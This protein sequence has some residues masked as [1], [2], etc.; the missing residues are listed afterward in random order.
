MHSVKYYVISSG[1]KVPIGWIWSGVAYTKSLITLNP[2]TKFDYLPF[3]F[4]F[5]TNQFNKSKPNHSKI[6]LKKLN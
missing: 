5:Y 3:N 6:M 4:F 2:H 1:L